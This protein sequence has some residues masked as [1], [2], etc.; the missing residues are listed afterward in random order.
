MPKLGLRA[1]LR[2]NVAFREATQFLVAGAAWVVGTD[3]ILYHLVHEPTAIARLE[4]AKGWTFIGLGTL[5]VY[6]ITARNVAA[7]RKAEAT[8]RAVLDGMADGVLVIGQSTRIVD[9]N[10][11]AVKMLG[12]P[13]LASLCGVD[14]EE[15]SRRFHLCY[16]DGRLVPPAAYISQRALEG[17][18][19]SS[20]KALIS[21]QTGRRLT[22]TV[23]AAPVRPV[24]GGPPAASVTV[25]RDVTALE[26]L[27]HTR[28]EFFAGAAHSLKTPLATIQVHAQLLAARAAS[29]L[30]KEAA[31]VMARQCGRMDRLVNNLLTLARLRDGSFR[32]HPA[33]IELATVVAGVAA[34]MREAAAGH[35]LAA[36]VTA[37]PW[38]FGDAT[39][40]GQA[41][42]NLIETAFL[43]SR[44]PEVTVSLAERDHRARISVGYHPIGH[45]HAGLDVG[46]HVAD[47]I[48][49][50]HNGR[51]EHDDATLWIELPAILP[52]G[53]EPRDAAG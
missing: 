43:T 5:F 42:A 32:L 25:M 52:P 7:L 1:L 50:A 40:L 6:A 36:E 12:V 33:G 19:V 34:E 38:I 23:T 48:V 3:L 8:T 20:Y 47:A 18:T 53:S 22:I 46:R 13:N 51:L 17:E 29:E 28:N 24:P 26:R 41:L 11:A 37:H 14:V 45:V 39:R 21:A 16:E 44:D 30:D 35:T 2:Q 4:T 49:Q 31:R 9:A 27:D 15:F 10:P